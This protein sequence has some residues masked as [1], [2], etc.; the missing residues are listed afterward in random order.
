MIDPRVTP[1]RLLRIA[2]LF[3][4]NGDTVTAVRLLDDVRHGDD[5]R[6]RDLASASIARFRREQLPRTA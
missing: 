5:P 1:E 6:C 2:D 4:M 3:A